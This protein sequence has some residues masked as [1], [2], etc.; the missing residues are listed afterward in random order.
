MI[1]RALKLITGTILVVQLF[2]LS[3]QVFSRYV[4]K[5]PSTVTEELSRLLLIWLGTLG[6]A[7]GF[8]LREHLAFDLLSEKASPL[9]KKRLLEIS[10]LSVVLFGVLMVVGGGM[11]FW[12]KL[13]LGQTTPVL[14]LP[15]A[16]VVLVLPL[17]G[18]LVTLAPFIDP[19]KEP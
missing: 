10:D 8:L 5:D 14:K 9:G 7:L 1:V 15:A 4:L 12:S 13:S 16:Y 19:P 17:A 18:I 3:W 11:L 6:T 2:V